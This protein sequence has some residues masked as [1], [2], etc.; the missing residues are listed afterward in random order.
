MS[1]IDWQAVKTALAENQAQLSQKSSR[2][3]RYW[4]ELLAQRA[5]QLTERTPPEVKKRKTYLVC[6]SQAERYA[7][8]LNLLREVAPFKDCTF[9]PL[10][11]SALL[12]ICNQ[13]G[14][15]VSVLDLGGLLSLPGASENRKGYVLFLRSTP[16]VGL[17][18]DALL[19][20]VELEESE[21][22]PWDQA[23]H[24]KGLA[25]ELQVLHLQALSQHGLLHNTYLH[26]HHQEE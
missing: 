3:I 24:L 14:T 23:P 4:S 16:P 22:I 17:R 2:D 8:D 19:E 20:L 10:A 1:D 11:P 21:I 7:L 5:R 12:G 25:G 13:R 6:L 15:M 26:T 18:V 9:L